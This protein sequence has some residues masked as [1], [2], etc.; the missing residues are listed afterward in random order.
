MS[1]DKF[2]L[3]VRF[4]LP[5]DQLY[6]N[7]DSYQHSKR[8]GITALSDG[9]S[10]SYDSAL[11][12]RILVR[13][14]CIRPEI[15]EQWLVRA[16]LEFG[17]YHNRDTLPWM[18]QAAFDRGSFASL[19]GVR[20]VPGGT[21]IEV[22]AVGDSLAVLCD[23]EDVIASWPY[24]SAADFLRDPQLISTKLEDN[25]FL[26]RE[27]MQGRLNVKWDISGVASPSLFCMTDALGHWLLT[28]RDASGS[29]ISTLRRITKEKDFTD[30]VRSEYA[31]GRLKLDDTT[32][33]GFW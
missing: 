20:H 6:R 31:S 13:H 1:L 33:L 30:F 14:Y 8:L 27:E 5:K 15:D 22:F 10:V 19:L 16:N 18:K 4:S 2:S 26:F 21:S 32:V 23:G 28:Q 11:W 24:Q 17:K 3:R 12:S 9:A 29:P 7:E 25:D